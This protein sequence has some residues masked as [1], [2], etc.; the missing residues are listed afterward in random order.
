MTYENCQSSVK[1]YVT[2]CLYSHNVRGRAD[3]SLVFII[4]RLTLL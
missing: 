3:D 2:G 1:Q 4:K